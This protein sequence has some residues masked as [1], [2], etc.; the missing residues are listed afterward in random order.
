MIRVIVCVQ[1]CYANGEEEHH[2][3]ELIDPCGR[4][5]IVSGLGVA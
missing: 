4:V 2:G 3:A 5:D 1:F